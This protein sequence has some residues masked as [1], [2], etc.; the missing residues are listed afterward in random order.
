MV[1]IDLDLKNVLK[2]KHRDRDQVWETIIHEGWRLGV[3]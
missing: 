1:K 3:S 2:A